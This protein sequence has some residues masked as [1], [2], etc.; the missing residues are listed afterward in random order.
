M[1]ASTR[2]SALQ[3]A[4]SGL[5][6]QSFLLALFRHKWKITLLTLTGLAAAAA[7]YLLMP[8][9][10]ESS[11]KLLVRY[12]L[13]RSAIDS[14]DSK[15]G[16]SGNRNNDSIINSEVEILTSWDL[17]AEVAESVGIDKLASK[18]SGSSIK[19]EAAR[20]ITMGL[21]VSALKGSNV[22]TVS[23][24]H[25]DP[26]LASQV[27]TELVT[28]YFTKHLEV[29][30]SMGAF[31]FVTQQTDQV[32]GRLRQTED[33]LKQFKSKAGILSL[34]EST[35]ALGVQ[36][37]RSQAELLAAE[38]ERAEQ[39]ARVKE[40]EKWLTGPPSTSEAVKNE[41]G[42]KQA[43]DTAVDA[44]SENLVIP[45]GSAE[46][47]RYQA[48][49]DKITKERQSEL[50]LLSK[51]TPENELV[52]QTQLQIATLDKQRR[53]MESQ[54]PS[55]VATS[56]AKTSAAKSSQIDLVAERARLAAVEAKTET[57]RAQVR[58]AQ[59]KVKQFSDIGNQISELERR[60]EVEETNYKYFESSLEKARI[61]EAL[62]PSKIPNINVVQK[63]SPPAKVVDK[64]RKLVGGIAASGLALGIGIAML[65]D[66]V[67]D[68]TVKA[69][70]ELETR[71]R[72]PVMRSIPYLSRNGNAVPALQNGSPRKGGDPGKQVAVNGGQSGTASKFGRKLRPFC[73]EIR[74]RII[75][76]F[77]VNRLNHKPKLIAVTGC[78]GGSGISTIAGGLAASLSETGDDK[79]LL[80]DMNME[81][82][83]VSPFFEGSPACSLN[84]AIEPGKEII[85]A[86]DNLY[87]ATVG[88]QSA[89]PVY[90][91]PKKFYEMLPR[92]KASDFDYIIF[93]MPPLSKSSATIAV[94]G[95]MD[96]V[97]LVVEAEKDNRDTVKRAYSDLLAAKADVSAV[98][99][100]T[101]SYAPQWLGLHA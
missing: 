50:E 78:D 15:D 1:T 57:L 94:A 97:L 36:L 74:D 37:A 19:A 5:D 63:P 43:P 49:T 4:P 84:E 6:A 38:S 87:L 92:I 45:P 67:I 51:Y 85:S 7:V 42:K 55:L 100:K 101:R 64:L 56:P 13:E 18:S 25:R 12:V 80:V 26:E 62:D 79:V 68:K 31:D 83:D 44:S 35:S 47:Q 60:K 65:I 71:L 70:S 30:R 22:I 86:A 29:H 53:S 52:K 39:L 14:V 8:P 34:P 48:L 2:P 93:D 54:F 28:R 11:A 76:H 40:L 98:V 66:L 75:L 90:L 33:E 89:T 91:G 58:T 69:S 88:R 24:R 17:A 23:F 46:V 96:K 20:A 61:D 99:N 16:T 73:N 21:T 95:F 77:E 32:R 82:E 3:P 41:A 59:D 10:Y 27:L 72:M 81:R 9:V